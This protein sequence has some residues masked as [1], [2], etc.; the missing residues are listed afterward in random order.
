MLR[1]KLMLNLLPL[2]AML[3]VTAA[4][5]IWLLQGVLRELTQ[6]DQQAWSVVER[7]NE[8]SITVNSI[9]VDLYEIHVGRERHLDRLIQ[10]VDQLR[11]L[12]DEMPRYEIIHQPRAWSVYESMRDRM[13]R[14]EADVAGLATAQDRGLIREHTESALANAVALRNDTL[15]LSRFVRDHAH[16]EQQSLSSWF[17]WLVL[18]LTLAFVLSINVSV[19]VLLR[20]AGMVLRPVDRLVAAARELGNERFDHRVRVEQHDEFDQLAAAYNRMAEQL[21]V[22]EQRKVEVLGQVALAMNH[23]LNNAMATIEM[24]LQLLGRHAGDPENLA[25]RLRQIRQSL[26]RMSEAVDSLKQARRVVLTDYIEGVKML[27]LRRSMEPVG[28]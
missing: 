28:V 5:A 1:R 16:G 19:M 13:P 2:L 4:A 14:F 9:E 22:S 12:M 25:R 21:E 17:R 18:G 23:E 20:M 26:Q 24:Q 7:V 8:L 10:A 6:I 15:P 27:D 3:V 11:G